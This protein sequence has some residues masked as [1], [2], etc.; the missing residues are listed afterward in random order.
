MPPSMKNHNTCIAF[1][2]CNIID[3]D[4]WPAAAC[5]WWWMA[6]PYPTL[7]LSW[8]NRRKAMRLCC[9]PC[10][11]GDSV[12]RSIPIR[13]AYRP[14]VIDFVVGWRYQPTT[15][16]LTIAPNRPL[17]NQ[18]LIKSSTPKLV[19][20][21]KLYHD[22]CIY[23]HA[24]LPLLGNDNEFII[25]D[26]DQ[27]SLARVVGTYVHTY[28]GCIY[29]VAG[30]I[31]CLCRHRLQRQEHGG[32]IVLLCWDSLGGGW[33]GISIIFSMA[34]YNGCKKKIDK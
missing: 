20:S 1:Y 8:I 2:C 16:G 21:L 5:C 22:S 12:H 7:P 23:A 14:I 31:A 17:W 15:T 9:S 27:S 19:I 30:C 28:V 34:E 6:Y 3:D 33:V 10:A 32:E 13:I 29:K 4:L 26:M 18:T 11:L 25:M 24:P